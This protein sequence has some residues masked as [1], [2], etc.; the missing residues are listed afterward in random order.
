MN[1]CD[2]SPVSPQT[3]GN[4][5]SAAAMPFPRLSSVANAEKTSTEPNGTTAARNPWY[6]AV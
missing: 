6:G 1:W 5:D 2:G 3:A 4:A